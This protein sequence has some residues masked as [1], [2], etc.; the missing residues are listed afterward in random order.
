MAKE[1]GRERATP[2]GFASIPTV[3]SVQSWSANRV[4][5]WAYPFVA[6]E[7]PR[8]ENRSLNPPIQDA[9]RRRSWPP[10]VAAVPYGKD[11]RFF[12]YRRTWD[13]FNNFRADH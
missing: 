6:R 7:W 2:C 13:P 8:L 3:A 10:C 4:A 5:V 12:V 1:P 11:L 9:W